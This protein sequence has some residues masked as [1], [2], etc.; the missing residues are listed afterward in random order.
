[1]LLGE[2]ST[3][4]SFAFYVNYTFA[5]KNPTRERRRIPLRKLFHLPT[6]SGE[7]PACLLPHTLYC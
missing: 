1:M 5:S 2:Y 6:L 7:L 4:T 3:V